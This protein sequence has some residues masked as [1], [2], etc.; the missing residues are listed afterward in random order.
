M[1]DEPEIVKEPRKQIK[2]VKTYKKNE[3]YNY[4]FASADT[5]KIKDVYKIDIVI[6]KIRFNLWNCL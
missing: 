4:N 5:I 1:T 3:T 2:Q 6:D